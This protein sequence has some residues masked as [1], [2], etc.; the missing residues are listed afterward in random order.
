LQVRF[1][2]NRVQKLFK[3]FPIIPLYAD[4][5][6]DVM[7]V[8]RRSVHW[9][10]QIMGVQWTTARPQKLVERYELLYHR[11]KIRDT[12]TEFTTRFTAMINEITAFTAQ[13]RIV[14]PK[15]LTNVF[16]AV[17][18][19]LKLLSKWSA[20]VAEQSAYK[21]SK[22]RTDDQYAKAGGK[23]TTPDGKPVQGH[24]YE[25]AVK[26]NYTEPELYAL[27]DVIGMIKG[28]GGLMLGTQL[29]HSPLVRR[30]IHDD[31]QIFLQQE[32]ARPLRKAHKKD[33]KVSPGS[34]CGMQ[35][36]HLC[37]LVISSRWR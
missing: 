21:F 20:K 27:I 17:L 15:M 8:L 24:D 3:P 37:F 13:K 36:C 14:T 16:Q 34:H 12:Y 31:T 10:E 26:Y 19:G 11:E 23:L 18:E 7:F 30:C 25:K 35:C 6:I 1:S 5:H 22:P 4:M 29:V 9:D 28:L 32:L 33:K 2:L